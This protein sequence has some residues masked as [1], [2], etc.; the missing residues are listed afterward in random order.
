MAKEMNLAEFV[1]EITLGRLK[2]LV[3]AQLIEVASHVGA[4]ISQCRRKK[5]IFDAVAIH[6]G[7][8][9]ENDDER[10]QEHDTR[11]DTGVGT[12]MVD[13]S[14]I[15]LARLELEKERMRAENLRLEEELVRRKIELIQAQASDSNAERPSVSRVKGPDIA[16]MA[17]S[18]PRF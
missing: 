12:G 13:S 9:V 1:K 4:D 16:K 3:K 17:N 8:S 5:E 2:G 10:S 18:V 14:R 11:P 6:L 7:L 15:E